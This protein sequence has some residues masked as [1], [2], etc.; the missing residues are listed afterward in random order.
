MDTS[1]KYIKISNKIKEIKVNGKIYYETSFGIAKT[2]K[3]A[4]RWIDKW[5]Q[6]PR[7]LL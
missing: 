6:K 1:E 3:Q 2:K 4:K 7:H 5:G